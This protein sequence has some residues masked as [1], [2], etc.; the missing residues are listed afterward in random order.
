MKRVFC[1]ILALMMMLGML[2]SCSG[3]STTA[4]KETPTETETAATTETP[5]VTDT[6]SGSETPAGTETPTA[7]GDPDPSKVP[8][9]G[10]VFNELK[11]QVANKKEHQT[12]AE[13]PSAASLVGTETL[14]P[15]D[16]QGAIGCC[17][18]E[19]ITYLQFTNAVA[20]YRLHNGGLGDWTPALDYTQC[21]SPKFTYQFAGASTANVYNIIKSMGALTYAVDSFAKDAGGGSQINV[22]GK[23]AQETARWIVTEG[24]G[25]Q[26]LRYRISNFEQ[27]F[28]TNNALYTAPGK[29]GVAMTTSDAGRA[30][31][32]KIKEAIATGNVVVTGGYPS[33][34]ESGI[35]RVNENGSIAKKGDSVITFA[36][37]E[38]SGGHQVA[39]VAYDDDLVV[40]A[41]GITMQGAFLIANSWGTS[42]GKN[43][44]IWVMYDALNSTSEFEEFKMPKS[45]TAGRDWALD[46]F[47]FIYWDR[48]IVDTMPVLY[49]EVEME[50]S[51]R[52]AFSVEMSRTD[53]VGN[54]LTEKPGIS[55]FMD[56]HEKYDQTKYLNPD[57]QPG[58]AA[59]N[60]FYTFNFESLCE[61]MPEGTTYED[62]I[63]GLKISS[64]TPI[65]IKKIVLKNSA[66]EVVKTLSF[67]KGDYVEKGTREYA[68]DF[69]KS[70][71]TNFISG[72]Y[73][74]Q[75]VASGR[76]IVP[77]G[78]MGVKGGAAKDAKAFVIEQN[79]E[80][81]VY[82]LHRYDEKY[83]LDAKDG[84]SDGTSVQ[85]NAQNEKRGAMQ[86]FHI[87]Y[88]D[89]GT[90]SFFLVD[91]SNIQFALTEVDGKITL[92]CVS[93]LTD[94]IKWNLNPAE[95]KSTFISAEVKDGSI[96][97]TGALKASKDA[98]TVT[99]YDAAGNALSSTAAKVDGKNYE[100]TVTPSASG[101]F[102]LVV[103][104]ADG[105]VAAPIYALAFTK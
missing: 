48:D 15:I 24:S 12:L 44:Y 88:N 77:D 79:I 33:A 6:P 51:D 50:V 71:G 73:T 61:V 43:G 65:T 13:L 90:F 103:T 14:P 3:K 21:F 60:G 31:I 52:D 9:T 85:F 40:T 47:C 30:M 100:A 89:D 104:D 93:T 35:K 70:L 1:L 95:T 57:G 101:S 54:T 68:F 11:P 18:S 42:Y 7:S 49:A 91:E 66:G 32:Q 67:G 62:F 86:K 76:Y 69:G 4:A 75:N 29:T 28:V 87:S 98:L 55:M 41:N 78:V 10:D 8:V 16:N 56:M 58:G 19:A 53:A 94:S 5:V 39:I 64:S 84:V 92:C 37:D 34:W 97:L 17:A 38:R 72:S 20:Q 99:L 36:T 102:Y 80:E 96:V 63:W 2:A 22:G 59:V 26:A 83:A 46:Q 27:T 23:L 74:L 25:E 105:A 82:I 81:N 45:V